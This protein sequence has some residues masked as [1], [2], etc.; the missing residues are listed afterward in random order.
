MTAPPTRSRIRRV[1]RALG[2]ITLVLCGLLVAVGIGTW[3]WAKDHGQDWLDRTVRQ[4]ITEVVANAAVPGYRFDI[5][6]LSTDIRSGNVTLSDIRLS[7]DSN[8][9]D[10]LRA[11]VHDVLLKADARAL[12]LYGL[13]IWTVVLQGRIAVDSI[14]VDTPELTYTIHGERVGLDAPFRGLVSNQSDAERAT[15]IHVRHAVIRQAQATM[16]DLS[17][18]LPLLSAFGFDLTLDGFHLE[19]GA[20]M[21]RPRIDVDAVIVGLDSLS[22]ELPGGYRIRFG[23]IDLNDRAGTGHVAG[24]SYTPTGDFRPELGRTE[25]SLHCD[26]INIRSPDISGLLVEQALRMG[27]VSVHGLRLV[28]SNDQ[29]YPGPVHYRAMPPKALLALRNHVLVDS[30]SVHD[31]DVLY[32]ERS[33]TNRQWGLIPFDSIQALITGIH[34]GPTVADG[35]SALRADVQ[36]RFLGAAPLTLKWIAHLD[37]SD[38]FELHASVTDLPAK[39]LAMITTP[40]LQLQ[41][42]AGT[43]QHMH[44][45]MNGNDDRARS[46]MDLQY[47][48]LVARVAPGITRQ[49][50]HSLM[51]SI[52]DH[53][54]SDAGGGGLDLDSKRQYTV[55]RDKERSFITFVWHGTRAGLQREL[56][57]SALERLNELIRKDS[58]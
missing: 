58:K 37:G 24:L 8:L 20:R 6:E 53:V 46:S 3:F 56:K 44:L 38:R 21:H 47:R 29:I 11:G 54:L 22:S 7:Y 13:S 40:L 16:E 25:I 42:L 5:G 45:S 30:L 41:P 33:E 26:S 32:R 10:S 49:E 51:G 23:R 9:V 28:A 39:N 52:L 19:R 31:A 57:R 36:A 1:L 55:R 15:G 17:G 4:R 48:G 50:R 18:R 12:G 43:I 2:M 34:N 35:N 27:H 14:I